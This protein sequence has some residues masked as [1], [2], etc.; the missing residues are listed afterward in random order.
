MNECNSWARD[1][2]QCSEHSIPAVHLEFVTAPHKSVKVNRNYV[3]CHNGRQR[4]AAIGYDK[5]Q[6]QAQR[7]VIILYQTS[8]F[9]GYWRARTYDVLVV[10]SRATA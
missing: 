10:E 1:S 7:M 5:T 6:F 9:G 8:R 3:A 4:C 2:I